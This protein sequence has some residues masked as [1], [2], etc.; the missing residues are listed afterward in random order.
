MNQ[1][2]KRR[3][4]LL[5]Q[6]RILYSDNRSIP[7]V[8]PRYGNVYSEL[9]DESVKKEGTLG[10]RVIIC[11]LLFVVFLFM[12]KKETTI[13]NKSSSQIK[14][15]ISEDME[16]YYEDKIFHNDFTYRLYHII[17]SL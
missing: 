13:F 10:I 8:H 5:H 14:E 6:T 7:A 3:E 4:D 15:L 17:D 9:Y 1:S 16:L 11:I 2:Q 12:D